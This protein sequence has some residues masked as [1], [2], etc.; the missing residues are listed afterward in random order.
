MRYSLA[1][2]LLL[3]L[4]SCVTRPASAPACEAFNRQAAAINRL[5]LNQSWRTLARKE[6]AARWHAEPIRVAPETLIFEDSNDAV[7]RCLQT[8]E[9]REDLL[10]SVMLSRNE[11]TYA[12]ALKD[13]A[14]LAGLLRRTDEAPEIAAGPD[15]FRRYI[16]I[17]PDEDR[18]ARQLGLNFD[19]SQCGG[20]WNLTVRITLFRF[21]KVASPQ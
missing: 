9:F 13:A 18:I 21:R 8:A 20:A 19:I 10:Q 2:I 16:W 11:P 5:A 6:V 12:K 17:L 15:D 4:L 14:D 3:P 7:C 1:S